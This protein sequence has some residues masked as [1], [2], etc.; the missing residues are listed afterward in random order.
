MHAEVSRFIV[1]VF[2]KL[3]L[4]LSLR[5]LKNQADNLIITGSMMNENN[6]KFIF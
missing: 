2:S 4:E 1:I 6:I 3:A 5:T